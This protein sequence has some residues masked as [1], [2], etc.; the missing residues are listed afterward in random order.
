M[1]ETKTYK[2]PNTL[3]ALP[4]GTREVADL[5]HALWLSAVATSI[6]QRA[7]PPT[8]RAYGAQVTSAVCVL[9]RRPEMNEEDGV[10]V[11]KQL[12][13]PRQERERHDAHGT[14]GAR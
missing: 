4:C 5:P 12:E 10:P 7:Q 14:V 11:A 1:E 8:A 9:A 6:T 13:A 3:A 2:R